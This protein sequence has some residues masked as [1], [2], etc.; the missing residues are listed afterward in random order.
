MKTKAETYAPEQAQIRQEVM[1][2]L[3]LDS[4]MSITL[5]E[6]DHDEAK[7]KHLMKLLTKT[8]LY[9]RYGLCDAIKYPE[10]Y[11][12]PWWTLVRF[13]TKDKY[14]IVSRDHRIYTEGQP[15]IRTKRY[16]FAEKIT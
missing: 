13:L 12:R 5:Y 11:K 3:G 6:L 16:V 8:R 9:F 1:E 2:I 10:Q 15:P 14:D 4:E 7:L